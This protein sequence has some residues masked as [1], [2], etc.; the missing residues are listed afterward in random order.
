MS[1]L[2]LLHRYLGIAVGALMVMWCVSGV[3]MMYV[4]Y[5]ALDESVRLK[6][7]TPIDWSGCCRLPDGLVAGS[8]P[9]GNARIEML[10]RRPALLVGDRTRTRLIDGI[11][12]DA[13]DRVSPE[14]AAAVAEVFAAGTSTAAPSFALIDHDQWTVSGDFDAD[15]P[16]YR[17]HLGDKARTDL[18]VSS[19]TGQAVQ[20]TTAS[21]RFWNGL[22]SVPHWLYFTELRHRASLWSQFVI[23]TSL[24]GCFL[25]AIGLYIGVRQV[26]AQPAGRWS[27]YR[28]FNW[29]HHIAGLAF[30][31]F[32]LSWVFSGLVSMNPWG[33]LE[34]AGA[35]PERA[36]LR[37]AAPSGTQF[38]GA[39]QS[40]ARVRPSGVVSLQIAPLDG[41]LFFIATAAS[42]LRRRLDA[43]AA[44]APLNKVDLAYIAA[45][46]RGAGESM[47]ASLINEEDN[48]YFSH[49]REVHR[50]PVYRVTLRDESA[51]RYYVDPVSGMLI[52]KIDRA[53]QRYRWWHEG[54]HRIDFTAAL[55]GRPRWDVVMLLLIS[56]VT[57]VCLTGAYL[58][59]RR[60]VENAH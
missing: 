13:I 54:L 55:R 46:L 11:T 56:G 59:Y 50:L 3:V 21:E 18:Y 35:Q 2:F 42:G 57:F 49:H 1:W 6:N 43:G 16:L 30:G 51:T 48:Y 20:I 52:V 40:F 7:L 24:I 23:Y 28:G 4:S 26:A 31:M 12:G 44:S 58:G 17:F 10:A 27:P 32:T 34:G 5:P 39:L 45:T 25:T 8:S 37:G 9:I 14:Q 38:M 36:Q 60:V 19:T 15:R 22:G 41:Q 53:G 29:W 47:A 33:W